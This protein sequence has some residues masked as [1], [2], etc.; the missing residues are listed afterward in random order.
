MTDRLFP[1]GV[2]LASALCVS[3]LGCSGFQNTDAA[4]FATLFKSESAEKAEE[5]RR[6][7]F[8]K[9]R[10]SKDLYWLLANHVQSGMTPREVGQVIG[11]QGRIVY[12]DGHFKTRGGHYQS[13]DRTWKWGPDRDGNSVFL[14]FREG[15]LVNFDPAQFADPML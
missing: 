15:G 7:A 3:S 12:N 9:S 10:A 1:L 14:V 13:G 11:E 8:Q 2:I 4:G 6:A 5:D